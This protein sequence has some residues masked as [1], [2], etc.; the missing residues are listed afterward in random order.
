MG[1]QAV[2]T[3]LA[4]SGNKARVLRLEL[5]NGCLLNHPKLPQ[6][7]KLLHVG[8]LLLLRRRHVCLKRSSRSRDES[9][10]HQTFGKPEEIPPGVPPPGGV[11]DTPC[12]RA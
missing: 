8:V 6:H 10:E 5:S 11:F 4:S 7:A 1:S 12:A 9:G 3:R 2:S